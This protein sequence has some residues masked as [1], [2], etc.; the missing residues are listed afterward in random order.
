MVVFLMLLGSPALISTIS[1]LRSVLFLFRCLFE[2]CKGGIPESVQPIFQRFEARPINAVK[3]T[4]SVDLHDDKTCRLQHL[5]VLRNSRAA[6]IHP[7][8]NLAHRAIAFT[9][10]SKN[11]PT[12]WIAESVKCLFNSLRDRHCLEWRASDLADAV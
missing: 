5:K 4:G 12:S 9:Y 3:T 1:I 10:T 6:D 8:G 11:G 2:C 7:V